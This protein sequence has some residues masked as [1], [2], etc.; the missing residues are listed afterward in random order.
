MGLLLLGRD[1]T[2]ST[3]RFTD[4]RNWVGVCSAARSNTAASTAAAVSGVRERVAS[5]RSVACRCEMSPDRSSASVAGSRPTRSDALA[6]RL[7]IDPGGTRSAA[8][9]WSRV[10][11]SFDRSQASNAA[12]SSA[13]PGLQ[14]ADV[15][16]HRDQGVDLTV[17]LQHHRDSTS[18]T[19]TSAGERSQLGQTGG[20]LVRV[21]Q[22]LDQ[23][24]RCTHLGRHRANAGVSGTASPRM[25]A[26][27]PSPPTPAVN[28]S[29]Q[30]RAWYTR[31]AV[32]VIPHSIVSMFDESSES[33]KIF[34]E[35][36]ARE[37]R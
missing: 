36:I 5:A 20:G 2:R 3:A 35:K 8:A 18:S 1:A 33:I 10:N 26:Q 7:R 15:P 37:A 9:T 27:A 17:D 4:A 14:Q 23:V 11:P 21:H 32:T 22:R 19:S 16:F 12:S 6:I 31:E 24:R 25:S 13:E 29:S 30:T 28:A 34:P